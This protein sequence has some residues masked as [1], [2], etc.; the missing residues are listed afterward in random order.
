M[1][2]Y[3]VRSKEMGVVVVAENQDTEN[4][5]HISLK[6]NDKTASITYTR[7]YHRTFDSV[8]PQKR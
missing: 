8:P 5:L 1:R 6:V 4:H 3:V 2:L 7:G